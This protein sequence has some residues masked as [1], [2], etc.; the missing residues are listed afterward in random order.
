MRQFLAGAGLVGLVAGW[1]ALREERAPAP[2][3]APGSQLSGKVVGVHDGDTITVL[4]ARKVQVKVRLEG[5]DAPEAKQAFGARAKEE[6]SA[7][8]FSKQ[9]IVREAGTER[10]G[11]VVGRVFCGGFDVNELMVGRGFAWRYAQFSQDPKLIEAERYARQMR[12]GLWSDRA[13]VPPWEWR[14]G[15]G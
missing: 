11:R 10:Y 3:L 7:L 2:A 13:P 9:V 8:V 6:L 14:G 12:R 5:I 1:F 4:T 15:K